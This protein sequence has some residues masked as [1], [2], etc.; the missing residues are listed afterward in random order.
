MN[1]SQDQYF[2][3]RDIDYDEL[4][5]RAHNIPDPIP[6]T[7][8][9]A[10]DYPNTLKRRANLPATIGNPEKSEVPIKEC[11]P[12]MKKKVSVIATTATRPIVHDTDEV[13]TVASSKPQHKMED[14]PE[15]RESV[16]LTTDI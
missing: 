6:G 16:R 5:R 3:D 14:H 8:P 1:A 13:M 15:K 12:F 10:T 9:P 4:Y 11:R 2:E 7:Q